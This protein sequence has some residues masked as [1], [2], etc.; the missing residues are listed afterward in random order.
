M[1]AIVQLEY[2]F[3]PV[4]DALAE[5][6][7]GVFPQFIAAPLIRALRHDVEKLPQH[8]LTPAAIGRAHQLQTD[9]AIRSDKTRWLNGETPTQ[10]YYQAM[11]LSLKQ[12]LNRALFLGL[13]EYECHYALYEAGDFY[14]THLDAFRGR[15]NRRVTTV[16]YLNE[17]WQAH[18]GGELIIYPETR[19]GTIHRVLPNA[20]TLVCFLSD[21]FPHEV[22]PATRNRL[23]VSGWFRIDDSAVPALLL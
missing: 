1:N 16:L 20:G 5:S 11:M 22:L 12:Q 15:S 8:A 17:D 3:T 21:V 19:Q 23:S 10:R 2:D 6:G 13:K 14:K 9:D 7:M 18:H 4:V